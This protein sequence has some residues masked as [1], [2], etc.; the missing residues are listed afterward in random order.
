METESEVRNL[1][2]F[3]KK[4]IRF[5]LVRALF[6]SAIA[7]RVPGAVIPALKPSSCNHPIPLAMRSDSL[8]HFVLPSRAVLL[9]MLLFPFRAAAQPADS[10]SQTV[11]LSELDAYWEEAGRVVAE[12]DFEGYARLFHEDAVLVNGISKRSYPIG[13]ALAG[14]KQGFDDTRAGRMAASVE[15]RFTERLA[16]GKTAHETGIFR[17]ASA[18]AG[19]PERVALIRF[20]SLSVKVDGEWRMLMEYQI[21]YAEQA[22]WDALA[23]AAGGS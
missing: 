8:F 19:E 21:G 1:S 12:G 2:I 9:L 5:R 17:Y 23:P 7:S 20:Q 10:A 16:G 14:W 6:G 15:F 11:L 13:E 4:K 3:L 18:M 22:E